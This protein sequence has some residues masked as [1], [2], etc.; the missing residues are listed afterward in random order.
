MSREFGD[1][2]GD[3]VV[4]ALWNEL[5]EE[6][7]T[8]GPGYTDTHPDGHT[9]GHLISQDDEDG[10]DR[11]SEEIAWDSHDTTDLSA[12][13]SAMHFEEDSG[14]E[15]NLSDEILHDLEEFED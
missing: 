11:T 2:P 14:V 15:E 4:E 6:L 1:R 7:G 3:E 10:M 5:A 9:I 12:E 8:D 13:E